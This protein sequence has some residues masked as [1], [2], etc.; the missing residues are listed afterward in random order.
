VERL[1]VAKKTQ[2]IPLKICVTGSRGKSSVTRLLASCLREAGDSVLAKT[3]GSMPVVI[4]PNAEEKEIKRKGLPSILEWKK[5]LHLGEKLQI[6]VLVAELMSIHPECGYAEAVQILKPDILI[7]TNIRQDHLA[8]MG[9]SKDQ[10]ARSLSS[11][12]PQNCTVFLLQEEFFPVFQ[13]WAKKMNSELRL[14]PMIPFEK[15]WKRQKKSTHFEVEENIWLTFNV[16]GFLGLSREVIQKGIEKA[17]PDFGSVKIWTFNF[18]SPS[19]KWYLIN[20]FA[21][22][23]PESTRIILSRLKNQ[24]VLNEKRLV[25]LLNLRKDRGDRTIQWLE[26]LNRGAFPELDKL[27]LTGIHSHAFKRE[28]KSDLKTAALVIKER[29]PQKIMDQIKST[30]RGEAVLVGIGNMEGMGKD[31]VRYWDSIGVPYDF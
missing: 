30:I 16:A 20:G 26:A 21:A 18:G 24:T 7:I 19:H 17:I 6:D 22:N 14:V 2:N 1:L 11:S 31:L 3:T 29:S 12:I 8:Q 13:D 10:I 23:D 9:H 25:A 5:I 28:L 4:Y 27:F 15:F